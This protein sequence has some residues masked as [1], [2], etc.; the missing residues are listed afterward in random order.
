VEHLGCE[1]LRYL[2]L[3]LARK[4]HHNKPATSAA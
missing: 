1:V 4:R 3:S 2:Q